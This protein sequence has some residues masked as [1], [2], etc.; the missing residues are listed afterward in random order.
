MNKP[1]SCRQ[2]ASQLGRERKMGPNHTGLSRQGKEMESDPSAVPSFA[3]MEI[4]L[5]G[6]NIATEQLWWEETAAVLSFVFLSA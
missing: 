4:G 1:A 6:G 3:T 5:K 2:P